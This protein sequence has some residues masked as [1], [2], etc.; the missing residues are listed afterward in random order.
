MAHPQVQESEPSTNAVP[1]AKTGVAA[2]HME[3]RISVRH[4]PC[5]FDLASSSGVELA[6]QA[7]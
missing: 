6:C 7:L 1:R 5:F 2:Y 3:L 4:I